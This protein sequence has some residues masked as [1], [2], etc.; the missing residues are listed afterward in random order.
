[1]KIKNVHSQV[2]KVMSLFTHKEL[3]YIFLLMVDSTS[4]LEYAHSAD[5]T[6]FGNLKT[7]PKDEQRKLKAIVGDIQ[8]L[9]YDAVPEK[10]Y[11]MNS[12]QDLTEYESEGRAS[13]SRTMRDLSSEF[14]VYNKPCP[15]SKD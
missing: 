12:Q 14:R 7:I 3:S 5:H 8:G 6:P 11:P 2:E 15:I 13:K 1:M 9:V 4:T 10:I